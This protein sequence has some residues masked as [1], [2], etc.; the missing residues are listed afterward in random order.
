[1]LTPLRPGVVVGEN[2]VGV[3]G[4]GDDAPRDAVQVGKRPTAVAAGFGSVWVTNSGDNS[5]TRI[6]RHTLTGAPVPTGGASPSGVTVGF[7]SVWVANSGDATV[8]RIDPTTARPTTIS[9]RPGPTGIVAAFGSI[10]VTNSLDASVTKIDPDTNEP[11]KVVPV[12]AGPTGIAAGAGYLWV[13]NQGDGTVT[14]F[15]PDT[16]VPDPPVPVGTGPTGIAVGSGAA[17]VTNNVQGSLSR[18]DAETLDVTA[19]ELAAKGGAYGVAARGGDVWVSNEYAGTLMRVTASTFRLADTIPLRGAPLG[20]AYVGDDL[21]F[22]NAAGGDA[23][24]RGGVLTMVG[25][26]SDGTATRPSSIRSPATTRTYWRLAAMTHDGLVAFRRAGGV[27]GAGLGSEPRH[28]RAEA[29]RW[30]THLHVPPAQGGPVLHRRAASR[31]RH[32]AGDRAHRRCTAR[33][34]RLLCA[35]HRGWAGLQETGTTGT[36]V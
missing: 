9:V 26:G 13:T 16:L 25:T 23:L 21:W 27:Q 35:G 2:A 3:I 14:R 30:G 18:I 8:T 34:P 15:H 10:W 6:D 29:D 24:H 22:T 7:G 28:D 12:G 31:R 17:W 11:V 4:P 32:P 33:G 20:L 19:R 1:M 36:G 5:L